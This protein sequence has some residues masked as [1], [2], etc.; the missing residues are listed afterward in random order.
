MN[1]RRTAAA[2][3]VLAVLLLSGCKGGISLPWQSADPGSK[4]A[5]AK[6]TAVLLTGV[7]DKRQAKIKDT[8]NGLPVQQA[9]SMAGYSRDRFKHWLTAD[10]HGWKNV[11]GRCDVRDAALLRDGDKVEANRYCTIKSGTWVDPYTLVTF[12]DPKKLDIDH[13]VP[14]ANA[15]RSGANTWSDAERA[16]Y[17]N[18][19]LVV[20]AVSASE[21]RAKGDKGPEAWKPEASSMNCAYATRWVVIKDTYHLSVTA[22]EKG[23][24]TTMLATCPSK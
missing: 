20:L 15:W 5:T 18:N 22:A 11:S 17:A 13:M 2:A 8:L 7:S 24:L 23:A 4:D 12:T 9:G 6:A 21:N 14:L 19:P 1:F 3:L 10:E 16:D